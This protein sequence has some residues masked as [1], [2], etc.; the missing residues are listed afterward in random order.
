VAKVSEDVVSPLAR[1][2]EW[3]NAVHDGLR[4]RH[5]EPA[6]F[7]MDAFVLDLAEK[8][9]GDEDAQGGGVK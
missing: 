3:G 4:L 5:T 1:G 6:Y 7:A 8:Q 2:Q 9:E